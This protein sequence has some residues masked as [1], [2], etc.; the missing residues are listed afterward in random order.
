[1][2]K[3]LFIPGPT[4]VR[5]EI[6]AT[7]SV[8]MIG[9]RSSEF[10]AL[11]AEVI[12]K[13][14][15]LLYT[16]NNVFLSTSSSTGLMEAAIRN[17]VEKKCINFV[18]GAFSE[19]WHNIALANGKDAERFDV[20]WGKAI[21]PEMVREKLETREYDTMT[22]AHNETSTGVMNPLYEIAEV[23][24]DFP[25]VC[26]L[27]DTVS[28]MA[29][30]KIEVDKLAIDVCLAGSQKALALPPGIAICSVSRKA[31]DK[32]ARIKNKGWYFD[33]RN[34]L[35][36]SEKNQ[37]PTTPAISQIY[38]LNVQMDRIFKE[39]LDNRFARHEAMAGYVRKWANENFEL[40]SEKGYESN[41]L[42]CI[43]NTKGISIAG[44][45]KKLGERGA[46]ISNGYKDM[47]EKNFRIA[48]MGDI[49]LDEIKELIVNID[50]IIAS[51]GAAE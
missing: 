12:P 29:G 11:Y 7:M 16:E 37:T 35:K 22:L 31:M 5:P 1:M 8:P 19:R 43:N 27:V 2:H 23:M 18:C 44:L 9:H 26:F 6:L 47:K 40:F 20:E 15:K 42:S 32:S 48:H 14:K 33:F 3:K 28:S 4:E 46:M 21:K 49:T 13:L 34:F 50:D 39:G 51:G 36:S 17:C 38:A 30:V 10:S 25:D 41:T 45:N 24:R